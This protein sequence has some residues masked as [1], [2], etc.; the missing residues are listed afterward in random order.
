VKGKTPLPDANR[1]HRDLHLSG[2][3]AR[4]L[5]EHLAARRVKVETVREQE[6]KR[7]AQTLQAEG[8]PIPAESWLLR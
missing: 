7:L 2:N 5:V 3:R 8:Q 6:L 1:L 4:R